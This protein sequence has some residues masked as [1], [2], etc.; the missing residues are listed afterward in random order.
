MNILS[1]HREGILSA[2]LGL[3][4][5]FFFF[6]LYPSHVQVHENLQLYVYSWSMFLD[7]IAMPGGFSNYLG[8]FLVQFFIWPGLG[9]LIIAMLMV[10]LQ[11]MVALFSGLRGTLLYPISVL[12]SLLLVVFLCNENYLLPAVVSTL[13]MTLFCV[14]YISI[15]NTNIRNWGA[16]ILLPLIY[17]TIGG[18]YVAFAVFVIWHEFILKNKKAFLPI[19]CM[20]LLL[21]SLPVLAKIFIPQQSLND[22][23]LG[24]DF[25]RYHDGSVS[26]YWLPLALV[27]LVSFLSTHLPDVVSKSKA[28][29]CWAI[30]VVVFLFLGI[31][32][33]LHFANFKKESL[34]EY[35]QLALKQKWSRIVEKANH[36]AP[37]SKM[38]FAFLNLALGKQN[39]L[40]NKL[41]D[42]NQVG[43]DGLLPTFVQVHN[44]LLMQSEI[45]Y[46]LGFVNTAQRYAFDSMESIP[47]HQRSGRL[48]K[49]LATTNIINGNYKVAQK[50]IDLL[51]QTLFYRKWALDAE[52]YLFDDDRVN[53][54]KEWGTLRKFKPDDDFIFDESNRD[55]MLLNLFQHNSSN[56]LAFDYLLTYCMLSKN[57][58]RFLS[59]FSWGESFYGKGIPKNYQEALIYAW[60][61]QN[62]SQARNIPF[63]IDADSK[64][65]MREYATIFSKYGK[66][67]AE[68]ALSHDFSDTYWFYL[69]FK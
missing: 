4:I 66:D 58:P 19:L 34:M 38:E 3:M 20:I 1:K 22:L 36:E 53:G 52:T 43:T 10:T 57:L 41:L 14:A 30:Q 12:P 56:K 8:T 40:G 68:S 31:C 11:Q 48:L 25:F 69:Q 61:Q 5:F 6:F 7:T 67:G 44:I 42:Y 26:L 23:F 59:A 35:D 21:T 63:P 62:R 29:M 47:N 33:V 15:K 46:H 17:W 9:A 65:R 60:G 51:K 13:L 50:Y 27:L 39:Q 49:R 64:N 28:N 18:A 16:V 54:H 37:T 45:Y 2:F 32:S 24:V 55:K